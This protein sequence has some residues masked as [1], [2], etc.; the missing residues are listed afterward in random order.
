[1][2]CTPG[3]GYQPATPVSMCAE[4]DGFNSSGYDDAKGNMRLAGTLHSPSVAWRLP[5]RDDYVLAYLNGASYAMKS[6]RYNLGAWTATVTSANR[7]G[8]LWF[9]GYNG[10]ISLYIGGRDGGYSVRCVGR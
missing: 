10:N 6:F 7:F 5:T 3:A 8:A 9:Y 1:M 4:A 2:D